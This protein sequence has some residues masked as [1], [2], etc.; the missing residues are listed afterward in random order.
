MG[1]K[2]TK[3]VQSGFERDKVG[4][5]RARFQNTSKC[6]K[7]KMKADKVECT[8][9]IFLR[10]NNLLRMPSRFSYIRFFTNCFGKEMTAKW[11]LFSLLVS[12]R[13]S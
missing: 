11:H 3:R 13:F 8:K 9:G 6:V 1:A 7:S 10:H 4:P 2:R 5:S 12:S